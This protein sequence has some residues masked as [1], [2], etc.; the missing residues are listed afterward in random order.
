MAVSPPILGQGQLPF[1]LVSLEWSGWIFSLK[2]F[3][4]YGWIDFSFCY[5]DVLNR[6]FLKIQE[7][8]PSAESLTQS[9]FDYVDKFV[10][11]QHE[12]KNLQRSKTMSYP[13]EHSRKTVE[14]QEY[15]SSYND[16]PIRRQPLQRSG[17]FGS[18][19]SDAPPMV[20][21]TTPVEFQPP[22]PARAKVVSTSTTVKSRSRTT[23]TSK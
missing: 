4:F 5:S 23:S 17:S 10:N 21:L 6:S 11:E 18:M 22:K 19:K 8:R 1:S 12:I 2:C 13:T 15:S 20:P 9:D 3:R 14:H 7:R 16:A